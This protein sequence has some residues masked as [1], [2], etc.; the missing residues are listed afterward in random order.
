MKRSVCLLL[1]AALAGSMLAGCGNSDESSKHPSLLDEINN[2]S[3]GEN[4]GGG[5]SSRSVSYEWVID[6]SVSAE[7]IIAPDGA[8]VNTEGVINNAYYRV[9]IIKRDGLYGF[10]DYKGVVIKNGKKFLQ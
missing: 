5:D 2:S 4:A 10:I 7:N 1:S 3:Q 6:P 9:A 8:Q